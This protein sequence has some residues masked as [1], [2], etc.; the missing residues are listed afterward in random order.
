[1]QVVE[2]FRI[3][4][5]KLIKLDDEYIFE[6][7]KITC[8]VEGQ[9]IDLDVH[10]EEVDDSSI[11]TVNQILR[12]LE[13]IGQLSQAA[14]VKD[15]QE[16]Q[17]VKD[18]IEE[19]NEDIFLQVFEEDEFQDFIKDT[20]PTKSME[21]RLLSLIRLVRIGVYFT[22]ESD[23]LTLDFAFG[24]NDTHGFRQHMIILGLNK[25]YE[26]VDIGIGG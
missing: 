10:L 20:A 11:A 22:G 25:E 19:W 5:V 15:F 4:K 23:F 12:E 2:F 24:Y 7:W 9:P 8:Q 14:L 13:K 3:G 21:E 1:M 6:D 18:Y 16:G 17:E 26:V